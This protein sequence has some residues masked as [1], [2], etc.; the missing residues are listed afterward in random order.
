MELKDLTAK[1]GLK[2]LNKEL[3]PDDEGRVALTVDGIPVTLQSFDEAGKLFTFGE[4][5]DV[6]P[7][8]V[9]MLAVEMLKANYLYRA[10]GGSTL[11]LDEQTNKLYL[12]RYDDFDRLD[13]E[14]FEKMLENFVNVLVQWH[15]IVKGYHP[16][17]SR[18]SHEPEE[19]PDSQGLEKF[20]FL[21]V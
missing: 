16:D 9:E 5:G 11:S 21:R 6:P 14:A 4:V 2:V 13:Y 18:K 19:T 8:G 10:T 17:L 12:I 20:M 1:L 15:E 3:V 7:E